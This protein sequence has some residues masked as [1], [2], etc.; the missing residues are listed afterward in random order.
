MSDAAS[1]FSLT[2]GT[3]CHF[4]STVTTAEGIWDLWD[5]FHGY[6]NGSLWGRVAMS[7]QTLL[8]TAA[9]SGLGKFHFMLF[10]PPFCQ[11][12]EKKAANMFVRKYGECVVASTPSLC[13]QTVVSLAN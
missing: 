6:G 9:I 8:L 7:L 2:G 10:Y 1:A 5:S 3:A 11:S 4:T 13:S 12:K